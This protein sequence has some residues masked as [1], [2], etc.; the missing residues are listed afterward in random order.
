MGSL[1]SSSKSSDY[2]NLVI[3]FDNVKPSSKEVEIYNQVQKILDQCPKVLGLINDYKDCTQLCSKAMSE[4]SQSSEEK[5][6]SAL[7]KSVKSV[8]VFYDFSNDLKKC[9]PVLLNEL[10][11]PAEET[12]QTLQDQQALVKQ[13]ANIL[14]FVLMFDQI[15]MMRPHLSNDFSYYRRYLPKFA[16]R[17]DIEVK[18]DEAS[19]MALFTARHC[20][21]MV[22]LSSATAECLEQNRH[23]TNAM[24]AM[25]NACLAMLKNKRFKSVDTN[26]YVARAM[27]GA[28]VLFD[29]VYPS[30]VF[31]KSPVDIK[32]I[33]KF[34]KKA[35]FDAVS[36]LA[37]IRY[38]SKNFKHQT[39]PSSI[40]DLFD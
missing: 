15:R 5:A 17:P 32:G 28:V 24:S 10:S 1:L 35:E 21:M 36:L 23:V 16:R 20:P 25:A 37:T 11:K 12:K 2:A 30:G 39:T 33:I 38:S 31:Y 40:T 19:A 6:F 3:D 29:H 18:A 9:V 4:P 13:F 7:L 14:D 27:V 26:K 8:K 34:L 22:S